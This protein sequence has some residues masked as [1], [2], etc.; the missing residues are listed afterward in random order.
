VSVTARGYLVHA[1]ITTVT[2]VSKINEGLEHLREEVIP[3]LQQQKGYR[4]LTASGDP[5]AGIVSVL[6]LWDTQG[7]LDASE[8]MVEKVRKE[9]VAAFG[10]RTQTVERFEQT[11]AEVGPNPPTLGSKLQIRRIKMDPTRVEDNLAFFISTV[12]PDIMAT[13]GFQSVRQMINR[14]TGEGVVGTVWADD[15]SLQA[16][17]AKADERRAMA[18]SR[19]VE[20]G[21]VSTRDLLFVAL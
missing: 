9:A 18:E 10:G 6:T 8:S 12:V 13:P 16:A 11:V 2:G 17:T 5:A 15:E 21:D 7:D 14:S 19:G 3:Q 20:F 4:G 1:R